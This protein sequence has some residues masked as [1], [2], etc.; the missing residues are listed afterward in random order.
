MSYLNDMLV[1]HLAET[2]TVAIST[3]FFVFLS[4]KRYTDNLWWT[5]F[6]VQLPL[7]GKMKSWKK[8]THGIE[9]LDSWRNA[10]MPPAEIMLCSTYVDKIPKVDPTV[11]K[12]SNEYLKFTYQSNRTPLAFIAFVILGILTFAEAGGTGMLIAPFV[13]A[14]ITGNQ[15]VWIGYLI[16]FVMAV[17]LLGL[18]HAAGA[19][20]YKYTAIGNALGSS[21]GTDGSF[22][23]QPIGCGDDQSKDKES[24][25]K[26]TKETVATNP[27]IRFGSRVLEGAHDRGSLVK[28]IIVVFLLA[29]LLS[30]ITWMRIEGIKVDLTRKT[31][32]QAQATKAS[33]TNPFAGIPGFGSNTPLPDAV[34]SSSD[35]AQA[36][37]EKD[38]TDAE[39]SQGI[40]GAVVLA[41]IYIITQA[42]GFFLSFKHSFIG[43]G[44][45]AYKQTRGEPS[46][47]SYHTKYIKPGLTRA[48]MRLNELRTHLRR[49]VPNYHKHPSEKDCEDFY[50]R[51]NRA[52]NEVF[53]SAENEP[54]KV[55]Q[56]VGQ[57]VQRQAQP[58]VQSQVPPQAIA[59]DVIQAAEHIIKEEDQD[60]KK[61]LL[62]LASAGSGQRR[63]AI[64]DAIKMVKDKKKE[65]YEETLREEEILRGL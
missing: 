41:I 59:N 4:W 10:G 1:G 47:Q 16:A 58:T 44:A 33:G 35:T 7:I 51:Q 43:E 61:S 9:N 2:V 63:K 39:F 6:L 22:T 42:L 15:M 30:G 14:E 29:G 48:N 19:D 36:T 57:A 62:D 60:K 34:A 27:K 17:G 31:A 64:L 65:A 45:N 20:A 26:D 54:I 13:A 46:F 24:I 3:L 53:G 55:D 5:D 8:D 21:V 50:N 52:P 28:P 25:D 32:E 12:N 37:V 40:G 49:S 18:T 38:V 11:F 56:P 23:G